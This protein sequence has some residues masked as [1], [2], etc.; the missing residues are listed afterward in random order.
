MKVQCD[1]CEKAE[2]RVICCADEAA[3][4]ADCDGRIHGANK[5]AS[6]HQRVSLLYATTA[7]QRTCCDIC[8]DK[9]GFF[10]CLED[11]ALLCRSCDYS[12]HSA[13]ALTAK[14]KRFLV[15]GIRVALEAAPITNESAE[16][17]Q[18]HLE[19]QTHSSTAKISELGSPKLPPLPRSGSTD[20]QESYLRVAPSLSLMAQQSPSPISYD[21]REG[22]GTTNA[23]PSKSEKTVQSSQVAAPSQEAMVVLPSKIAQVPEDPF[24][25][26]VQF[27]SNWEMHPHPSIAGVC[28]NN[29]NA[30][31]AVANQ[32]GGDGFGGK[33]SISKYFTETIPGWRVDELLI[34]T[35]ASSTRN[36]ADC[37]PP[38]TDTW[39]FGDNEWQA[40]CNTIEESIFAQ[41]PAEVPSLPHL[42]TSSS[43]LKSTRGWWGGG[44]FMKPFN[45]DCLLEH[46]DAPTVPDVGA[47]PHMQSTMAPP[48]K[49]RRI[50][51]DF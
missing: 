3:L 19:S 30:S 47:S 25:H 43:V 41:G 12:I 15:A 36:Y 50:G 6:K 9:A 18:A 13:N 37:G 44:K 40:D 29:M 8:Q 1:V 20:S 7:E 26:Q 38:K 51:I 5:L 21:Q 39:N 2:A 23:S 24:S 35:D 45:I 16:S 32:I 10:F 49:R 14:H 31:C 34:F 4:C 33:S 28:T 22:C 48:P 11:R 27:N 17:V 42:P 46:D